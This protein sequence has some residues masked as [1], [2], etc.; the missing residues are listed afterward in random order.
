M[1]EFVS[2]TLGN[3]LIGTLFLGLA[4][5]LTFLMFYVW[6][7]PFDHER[8]KSAAPPLAVLSHRL[9]GYLFVLIYIYIMWTMVPRLWSYQVELPAR[10]VLHLA[11]GILIGALLI[12]KLVIVRFF[13]HME[14]KLVPSLGI[15]L[16]LCSFLL[17]ALVLPFSLREAYLESSAL[18]DES[19]IQSRIKRVR[20]L[21]P[22]T[23]L[24][25]E[26][27][28]NSLASKKG[29]I[30]GRRILTAKCVQCHD[31]RTVLVR[32]RT[33]QAWQQTVS[34]MANRSTILNPITEDD[35]WFVTAYLIAVSPTLQQTLKERRK[36]ET[37]A[38]ESQSSMRSAMNL[39][40]IED[41]DYVHADA[42]ILFKQKCSQCHDHTQVEQAPPASRADVIALVQR[43]VGNGLDA[44][45]TELGTII[46]YLTTTYTQQ[47]DSP[48]SEQEP[49]LPQKSTGLN[50]STTIGMELYAQ[51]FCQSC[52]GLRGKS[53]VASTYPILAGQNRD[54][55]I[56]QFKD[57]QSGTR[58]NASAST[59]SA[60]VQDVSGEEINAIASYLSAQP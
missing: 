24:V 3:S 1:S 9:M 10:T 44:S 58:N 22:T 42:Q 56:Q 12:L 53:P 51:K 16:F 15:G 28:L 57:I 47:F 30:A 14:A 8:Y 13:K 41:A 59:M 45:E 2:T 46:R 37:R 29:L 7:F 60:L 21:L 5:A 23:G 17:M 6:K 18:G 34:R 39:S 54:Y 27:L 11:L 50:S 55:L 36:M 20:E 4:A 19:M 52:H 35:Q 25:D 38:I 26:K 31:L 33:P 32:P 48:Q 40:E 49:S 43:M